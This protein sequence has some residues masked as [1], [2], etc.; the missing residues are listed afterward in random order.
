MNDDPETLEAVLK[1]GRDNNQAASEEN[2]AI[3]MASLEDYDQCIK[4]LHRF[5][6]RISLPDE[7]KERIETV[8]TMDHALIN[9]IQ[10]NYLLC[11]GQKK[12]EIF[13][14][15]R[16]VCRSNL[17][18]VERFLRFK[19][20]SNPLYISREFVENEKIL[21]NEA[22]DFKLRTLDPIRKSFALG[23]YSKHLSSNYAQHSKEYQEISKKCQDFAKDVLEQCDS[24]QEVEKLL[25][26][27]P[28]LT[29]DEDTENTNWHLALWDGHEEFVGHHY[30]QNF[31]WEKITGK[32][33]TWDNY[34]LF[35]R[36][37]YFPLAVLLF[38][39]IPLVVV[40]DTLFRKS[41]ILFVSPHMLERR[42]ELK[43]KV[44]KK[45]PEQ[46]IQISIVPM[47][48]F[49]NKNE[50]MFS[51]EMSVIDVANEEQGHSSIVPMVTDDENDQK[52]EESI[53]FS[54]FRERIHRPIFR[55][56]VYHFLEVIFLYFLGWS[57]IDPKDTL[58]KQELHGYDYVTIV[59]V[60]NYFLE[61]VI[62]IIRRKWTFFYS[63]W[64]V[65]SLLNHSL[66][67]LGG[68]LSKQGFEQLDPDDSN[69]ANA[70]GNHLVNV[71][72]TLLSI[73]ASM[74]FFRTVRWLLLLKTLGPVVVCIMRVLKDT[75]QIFVLFLII[76][77]SFAIGTFSMFKPFKQT[78]STS[79]YTNTGG[80]SGRLSSSPKDLFSAM[81]W[82]VFD[83]GNSDMASIMTTDKELSL[84]F[85]HF[86]GLAF[87]ALYQ[88]T[89]VILLINI[90]IAMM[91]TTYT[92]VSQRADLEW[93]Y[94]KSFYQIQFLSSRAVFPPPF[95][96]FYYFAKLMYYSMSVNDVE[97][98]EIDI[99]NRNKD[100][101]KLLLRLVK[102]KQH[103]DHENSI[104]DDFSDLRQDIQNIVGDKQKSVHLEIDEL[105]QMMIEFKKEIKSLKK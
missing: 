81:F 92:K 22:D 65:Y 16:K 52:D 73:A 41:D 8:L 13:D 1:W 76:Y 97:D 87:W 19:A 20:S 101:L 47:M 50:Q 66:F 15:V 54:F 83:P 64:N 10:F 82:R 7:D 105:K 32:Y 6:Y 93:K 25:E 61:D 33:F 46:A 31:L 5:G 36:I 2:R 11:K 37:L 100:Y 79:N 4:H 102:T 94:S 44:S 78:N 29:D 95:R 71:G 75:V 38:C 60:I 27:S 26:Y 74:A 86:M 103:S 69:R 24:I 51:L 9:D 53:I 55:M 45:A 58:D 84:Q 49:D 91:N 34:F 67:M 98:R 88:F 43:Y 18:P 12:E 62:D 80:D 14:R 28:D 96:I 21:E 57:M 23:K 68:I 40:V 3:L 59:F 85:S 30:F 99:E 42:K 77:V 39:F 35:W 72:S 70:S 89:I 90:L 48:E 17:D 104:K 63:F 56:I